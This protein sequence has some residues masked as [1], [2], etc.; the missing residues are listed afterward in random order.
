MLLAFYSTQE[1]Y[2]L[3]NVQTGQWQNYSCAAKVQLEMHQTDL[4]LVGSEKVKDVGWLTLGE[5]NYLAK[6]LLT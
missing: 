1:S 6:L 2:Q 5:P 3:F 4:Q